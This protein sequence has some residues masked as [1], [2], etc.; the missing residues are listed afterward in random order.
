MSL[1]N[2]GI[3]F[4]LNN[5][6]HVDRG[7][8]KG[9]EID[10]IN[11][12][13]VFNEIGYTPVVK[14]NL[15]AQEIRGALAEVKRTIRKIHTSV[16]LVFMS[17]GVQEGIYGSDGVVISVEDIKE[18]FSGKNCPALIGKPKIFFFQACRGNKLTTSATDDR[19]LSVV[20]TSHDVE[21]AAG[22]LNALAKET[23]GIDPARDS[24]L[25]TLS[26]GSTATDRLPA[27]ETDG[28]PDNADMYIAHATSEGYFAIRDR[29]NGSWFI[30]ALCEELITGAHLYD[31]DTIMTKV[32]KRVK[33]LKGEIEYKGYKHVTY[34]TPQAIK[35]GIEKKIYFLP[36]YPPLRRH[37]PAERNNNAPRRQTSQTRLI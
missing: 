33:K 13:H 31:L 4:V 18:M 6:D 12:T 5:N 17:H 10:V 16:V 14:Q 34:Q 8:R 1:R 37:M 26:T 3:V 20:S 2:K 27:L 29:V 22:I 35:Q 23:E 25:R 15:T 9:S 30:Q 7:V 19:P 28:V 11:V 21:N 36:K 32:A 24:E